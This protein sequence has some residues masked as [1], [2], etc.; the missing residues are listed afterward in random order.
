MPGYKEL[1][2]YPDVPDVRRAKQLAHGHHGTAVLWTCRMT[3][4]REQAAIIKANLKA[5]GINVEVNANGLD[6]TKRGARFDIG[7]P[8]GYSQ[9]Y[10]D[11]SDFMTVLF[12]GRTITPTGNN[13]T[14]YFND[15]AYNRRF[16]A[17][18]KLTGAARYRAYAQLDSDLTR[19]AAPYIFEGNTVRQAFYSARVGCQQFSPSIDNTDLAALCIRRHAH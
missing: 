8:W 4:C 17:A 6:Q 12:D 11:P 10:F 5:I 18:A 13:D 7:G 15:P 14:S 19:K 9:D 2:V 16:D 1:H 3:F